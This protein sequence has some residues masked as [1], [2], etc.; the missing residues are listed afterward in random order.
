MSRK[1]AERDCRRRWRDWR[2]EKEIRWG[3]TGAVMA[4]FEC[5]RFREGNGEEFAA[6]TKLRAHGNGGGLV[7]LRGEEGVGK[8]VE[9]PS[10]VHPMVR[11]RRGGVGVSE[12]SDWNRAVGID[13]ERGERVGWNGPK[14]EE[15][16]W[17]EGDLAQNQI[18]FL[19]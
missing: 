5:A 16:R 8:T 15:R 6:E 9:R 19:N 2:R 7:W 11:K 1:K 17:A 14:A 13:G 18:G 3:R 12:P 4:G 10:D